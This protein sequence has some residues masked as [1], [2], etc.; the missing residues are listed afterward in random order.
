ME[1]IETITVKAGITK[2]D[3]HN[4][5]SWKKKFFWYV[6]NAYSIKQFVKCKRL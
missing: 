1:L 5:K 4:T 6:W 2:Q 3:I